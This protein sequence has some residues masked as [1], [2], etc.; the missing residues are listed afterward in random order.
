MALFK[1]KSQRIMK[2]A[3]DMAAE[4]MVD[5]AAVL[6]EE[7]IE[8][9]LEEKEVARQVI[10]FLMDVGHPD[11]AARLSERV[12]KAHSDLRAGVVKMLEEKL[13]QYA[14]STELL[15]VLW[16]F[17]L[18][19]KDYNGML[20]LLST[21][22]R[23]TESRFTDSV[24][25]AYNTQAR[26][27]GEEVKN[28]EPFLAMAVVLYRKGRAA[29]AVEALVNAAERSSFP[30]E[31]LSRLSGWIANRTG[32]ADME[33]NLG[34]IRILV[35]LSDTERAV[36]ELTTLLPAD[37][38]IIEKAIAIAEKS[39]VHADP[40]GR[41]SIAL[42]RLMAAAGRIGDACTT[43]E[44]LMDREVDA[45]LLDQAATGV[46][47]A[48]PGNARAHLLQAR[49]RIARGETTL[50]VES[51]AKVFECPDLD[52]APVT[53][54]CR[55]VI[56]GGLDREGRVS[57]KLGEFLVERGSVEEAVQI[58]LYQ[59]E[60]DPD[61][62][63]AQ[64]QKLLQ[65]EKT[66]ASVLTLLAV[67]KLLAGREGE[68]GAALQHLSSR[69]DLKSK[70][71]VAQ[72]LSRL[73]HLM[74]RFPR[75]RRFRASVTAGVGDARD[76]A[77]DWLA[78]L[79]KGEKVPDDGFLEIFDNGLARDR[80]R[81][82][83]ES[84]FTPS[85]P[86]GHLVTA[87][88]AAAQEDAASVGPSMAEACR[89]RSLA[90]RMAA[91]VSDMRLSILHKTSPETY[92]PA[93]NDS[94]R[95]DVVAKILP[96]L[97]EPGAREEWM[98][99]LASRIDTGDPLSTALF[100]LEYFIESGRFG[101]A[102]VSVES[103]RIPGGSAADLA[104]GCRAAATGDRA[105]AVKLLSSAAADTATAPMA[106]LVLESLAGGE[107]SGLTTLALAQ[108]LIN[109]GDL[110]GA[111]G[112]LAKCPE[113]KETLRFL[114]ENTPGHLDSWELWK[115]LSLARLSD[116][117]LSG[118]R[119]AA[120]TAL[121]INPSPA[122]ELAS[123]ALERGGGDT[124]LLLFGITTA[125]RHG[126]GM[127]VSGPARDLLRLDPRYHEQLSV[128]GLNDSGVRALVGIAS[129]NH[130]LFLSSGFAGDLNPPAD[131]VDR[132]LELWAREGRTG[133]VRRLLDVC[134]ASGLAVQAH[135]ARVALAGK[136]FPEVEE[137]LLEDARTGG[138]ARLDFWNSV[139]SDDLLSRGLSEF[140]APDSLPPPDE[141][142]AAATALAESGLEGET[143]MGFAIRLAD[144]DNPDLRVKSAL[145]VD[146]VLKAST[147]T[148]TPELVR[149][150]AAAGRTGEAFRAARGSDTLLATLR[151][152]VAGLPG[153]GASPEELLWKSGRREA[154]CAGWLAGYRS[155]GDP[156]CLEKLHW[157]LS[158][159]GLPG[160][161]AA[162]ER[163]MYERHP[164]LYA[165][166]PAN[167]GR[168]WAVSDFEIRERRTGRGMTNGG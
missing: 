20:D 112:V 82:I 13:G 62:V 3:R 168:A 35:A 136:G 12:I 16:R 50:G 69:K 74:D 96:L 153:T 113:S 108:S 22:D 145:L 70:S 33:V 150:L 144:S 142:A 117:D 160:E 10:P 1:S 4:D 154:A 159:M 17:R 30:D 31:S 165:A 15:K 14:R 84:G 89:E 98:D 162:L 73:S 18:R 147:E 67:H 9:I 52:Q 152:T 88:A 45:N 23:L 133:A 28:T 36:A 156:V 43:L 116:G 97:T 49:L 110:S 139:R 48:A 81:E 101:T 55:S 32:G 93:L 41:A 146:K 151:E 141:A 19:S 126:T 155:T 120:S 40:S 71:D 46:V 87:A 92:L 90:D 137:G 57:R 25:S 121:E 75:L 138:A 44:G 103:L 100:R 6:I 107:K 5:Q 111:A 99:S 114:E 60:Q 122:A 102:A 167:R 118:F 72:V 76:S 128:L 85:T 164:D 130:E 38:E 143:L 65:R 80:S 95:G 53:E 161:T 79:L 27:P 61:W 66:N 91:L 134:D 105:R 119:M 7:E 63:F 64:I 58:V 127:D 77:S 51:L 140:A 78:L 115:L 11:L 39:L 131:S 42:A 86:A 163:F 166:F 94:G 129:G 135:R 109:T 2:K 132:C 125:V 158:Q 34:R 104:A 68:A 149:L 8:N 47:L 26:F 124:E 83:L 59:L 54:I 106:R 29:E 56:E 148:A 123:A 157:A 37:R 21:V 24:E